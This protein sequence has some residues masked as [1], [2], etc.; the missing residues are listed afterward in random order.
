M[1]EAR[2]V[3]IDLT[4]RGFLKGLA[5]TAVIAVLPKVPLKPAQPAIAEAVPPPATLTPPPGVT[6]NWVRTWLMGEPDF[7]NVE[8]RIDNGRT[9]VR[10]SAHPRM[11]V[12]D[13]AVAFERR[14][15][16][17]MQCPTIECALRHA[18][19]QFIK[20]D[21]LPP[22]AISKIVPLG[23]VVLPS[24]DITDLNGKPF[25]G[26]VSAEHMMVADKWKRRAQ[27][28]TA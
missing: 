5:G 26:P 15:L 2:D 17:L 10:P 7:A 9:F 22:G 13:A 12:E 19:E 1:E 14:G 27:R 28:G 11:L 8:E 23:Y 20:R 4:R 6:Y 18:A 16:I 3:T 24:G 21:K 25:H